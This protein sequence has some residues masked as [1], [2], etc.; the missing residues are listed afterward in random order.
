MIIRGFAMCL[1]IAGAL[2]ACTTTPPEPRDEEQQ[3][4][5]A[6]ATIPSELSATP[7][8]NAAA[9]SLSAA[10]ARSGVRTRLAVRIPAQRRP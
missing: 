6:T 4:D 9:C 3:P 8:T 5:V 10:A 1:A 2:A 7:V